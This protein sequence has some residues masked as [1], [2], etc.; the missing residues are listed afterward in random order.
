MKGIRSVKAR[1][2]AR[3][4]ANPQLPKSGSRRQAGPRGSPLLAAGMA[5]VLAIAFLL[6]QLPQEASPVRFSL[7]IAALVAA[8]WWLG[9]AGRSRS[10]RAGAATALASL[11]QALERAGEA[12]LLLDADGRIRVA[13]GPALEL[14]GGRRTDLEGSDARKLFGPDL[15]W[16]ALRAGRGGRAR[17]GA[18]SPRGDQKLEAR[19]IPV[20]RRGATRCVVAL[21]R[22][23]TREAQL[24]AGAWRSQRLEILGRMAEQIAHG[25]SNRL[26]VIDGCSEE[27]LRAAGPAQ[28]EPC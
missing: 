13:N 10:R 1:T 22:D 27:A 8:S 25:F 2:I 6:L 24:E 12:L 15:D 11:G 9:A 28:R 3:L 16:Q 18:F 26:L 20:R 21:L 17:I 4:S 7:A 14:I 5:I 23:A 19:L